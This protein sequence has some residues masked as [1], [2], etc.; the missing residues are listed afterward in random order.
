MW[1]GDLR[2]TSEQSSVAVSITQVSDIGAKYVTD[3]GTH[4]P[5]PEV[6]AFGGVDIE[7][8]DSRAAW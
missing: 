3:A 2:G 1:P 4:V 7:S 8:R 5:A 6:T